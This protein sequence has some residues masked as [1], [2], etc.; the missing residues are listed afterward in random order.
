MVPFVFVNIYNFPKIAQ[1]L[2]SLNS[3]PVVNANRGY[4]LRGLRGLNFR[5]SNN[6]IFSPLNSPPKI[7]RGFKIWEL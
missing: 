7:K 5:Y 1:L 3:P 2:S 6:I 4:I